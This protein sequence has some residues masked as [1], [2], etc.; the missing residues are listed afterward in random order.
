M[1]MWNKICFFIFEWVNLMAF[2]SLTNMYSVADYDQSTT[3]NK[4]LLQVI[5]FWTAINL[6]LLLFIV[7]VSLNIHNRMQIFLFDLLVK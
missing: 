2:H 1:E 7:D 6:L 5:H 4:E 3:R